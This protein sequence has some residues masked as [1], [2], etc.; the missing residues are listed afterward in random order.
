LTQG[1]CKA[2]GSDRLVNCDQTRAARPACRRARSPQRKLRRVARRR[3][4]AQWVCQKYI[5]NPLL[6]SGRKFDI[7]AYALAAPDGRIYMH[8]ACYVRTSSCA[9]GLADLGDK[10][11]SALPRL[12]F[13]HAE[14]G[15]V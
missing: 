2:P 8:R 9:F 3:P 5:E 11:A 4:G 7:R 10:C 1:A 15:R 14:A 12:C 13:A 6:L